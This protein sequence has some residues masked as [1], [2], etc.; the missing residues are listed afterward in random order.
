MSWPEKHTC[1]A[2]VSRFSK[3]EWRAPS[4]D[5]VYG[6]SEPFRRCDYCGSMHPEDLVRL[7]A[8]NPGMRLGGAD[9]KYGWPHKFYVY[10]IPNLTPGINA[11]VGG[12]WKN[13]VDT[14]IMGKSSETLQAKFYNEHLT[15]EG[16]TE[17]ERTQL[18][19]LLE[20]RGGILF[21]FNDQGALCY[22]AP[23]VGYQ[24]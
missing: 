9:W 8:D 20:Q 2:A 4:V 23:H 17:P 6:N 1:H 13:G 3:G 7:L 15:D 5:A 18:I 21:Y 22:Q 11:K 16:L 14:P 19:L 10:G 24:R 12:S